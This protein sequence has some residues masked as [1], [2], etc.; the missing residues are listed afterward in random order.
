LPE[1]LQNF[2]PKLATLLELVTNQINGSAPERYKY[3]PTDGIIS[4]LTAQVESFRPSII[5]DDPSL[6]ESEVL[7]KIERLSKSAKMIFQGTL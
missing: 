3:S 6:V 2:K 1:S 7:K 5:G 4:R